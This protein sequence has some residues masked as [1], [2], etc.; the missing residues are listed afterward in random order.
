MTTEL[1]ARVEAPADRDTSDN[2]CRLN[3]T[4]GGGHLLS[5]GLSSFSPHGDGR[6]DSLPIFCRLPGSGG[7]LAVTVFN[8]AGRRCRSVFTGDA[9]GSSCRLDWNGRDD[10]GRT[11]PTGIYAVLLEYRLHGSTFTDKLPVVLE[12]E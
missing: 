10:A 11:L 12:R 5:L 2:S 6:E 8:L 7:K 3:V 1:W 4:P 9:P